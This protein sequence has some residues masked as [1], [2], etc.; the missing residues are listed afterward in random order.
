MKSRDKSKVIKQIAI[1]ASYL[2]TMERALF[3]YWVRAYLSGG[4][5]SVI[6]PFE[7]NFL[8]KAA[9]CERSYGGELEIEAILGGSSFL[10]LLEPLSLEESVIGVYTR[11]TIDELMEKMQKVHPVAQSEPDNSL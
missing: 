11:W 3:N 7:E 8:E 4:Y 2:D 5:T 10:L 9:V 6:V 1:E